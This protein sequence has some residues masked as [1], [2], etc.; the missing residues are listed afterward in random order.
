MSPTRIALCLFPLS[1]CCALPAAAQNTTV[2]VALQI[3][4]TKYQA[5]G[6]GECKAAQQ[7]SIY[8]IQA[9]LYMVAHKADN[10]SLRLSVWQPKDGSPSMISF[11]ASIGS[12]AYDVDTVKGGTKRDTK[13]SGK[14]TVDKAGV[15]TIE[16]VAA[17]GEK[18]TGKVRCA[19]FGGIQ[20]EG[21]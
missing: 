20:A 15:F 17:S 16:A 10:R 4:G 19:S 18:I 1:L 6:K 13:G 3:G 21:G 7:A 14:A 2:E 9:A 8:G 11:R 12:Q 5:S